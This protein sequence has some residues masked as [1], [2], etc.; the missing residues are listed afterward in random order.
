MVGNWFERTVRPGAKG[1]AELVSY[2]DNAVLISKREDNIRLIIK[3]FPPLSST[4]QVTS[5]LS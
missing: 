1:V 3:I 4:G 2:A 5:R